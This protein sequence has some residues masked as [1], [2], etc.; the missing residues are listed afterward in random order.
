MTS[1]SPLDPEPDLEHA[2]RLLRD[3]F[4]FAGLTENYQVAL[5]LLA[6]TMGWPRFKEYKIQNVTPNRK[7]Q[8]K[9][10]S[11]KDLRHLRQINELD[12]QLYQFARS[13]FEERY[14]QMM[15]DLLTRPRPKW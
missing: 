2:K 13:L 7:L 15:D 1:A 3:E 5:D 6:Y 11:K 8:R 10:L 14:S 12:I 4:A 9:D